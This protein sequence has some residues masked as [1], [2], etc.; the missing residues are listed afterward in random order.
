MLIWYNFIPLAGQEKWVDCGKKETVICHLSA[1]VFYM[2]DNQW[3][4]FYTNDK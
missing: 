3:F 4:T 1:L 2:I